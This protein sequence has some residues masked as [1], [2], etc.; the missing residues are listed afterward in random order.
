MAEFR[1][2]CGAGRVRRWQRICAGVY[3]SC[4][5]HRLSIYFS[6]NTLLP[7][8]PRLSKFICSVWFTLY[9]CLLVI[10]TLEC[11]IAGAGHKS[12]ATPLFFAIFPRDVFGF[13][14][15]A[16]SCLLQIEDA[17][18][19]FDKQT[20][21]HRGKCFFLIITYCYLWF[22]LHKLWHIVPSRQPIQ[23]F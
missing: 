9:R 15:Y 21:R 16:F 12:R 10:T 11:F 19:M 13:E 8:R 20:N 14:V 17:M 22:I 18:L 6:M 1:C 3:C 2:S 4:P 7:A 5:S 23:H